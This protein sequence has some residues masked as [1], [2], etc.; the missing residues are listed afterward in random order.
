[1]R[2]RAI[3]AVAH[4]FERLGV[5]PPKALRIELDQLPWQTIVG[6]IYMRWSGWLGRLGIELSRSQTPNERQAAFRSEV[7]DAA[8]HGQTIVEAYTRERYG[9]QEADHKQVRRAWW[10]MLP[11]LWKAWIAYKT[12]QRDKDIYVPGRLLR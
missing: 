4:A 11:Y 5:D 9:G 1:M 10:R 12:K 2:S 6:R 7:P 3:S 8:E